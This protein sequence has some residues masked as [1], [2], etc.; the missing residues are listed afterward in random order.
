MH[1]LVDSYAFAEEPLAE[2]LQPQGVAQSPDVDQ[3]L[4]R[5]SG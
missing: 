3:G 5:S 2:L 4:V 1:G